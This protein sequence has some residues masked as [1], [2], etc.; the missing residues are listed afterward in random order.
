MRI[1]VPVWNGR[2]SPVF[3]VAERMLVVDTDGCAKTAQREESIPSDPFGKP[4]RLAGL[5]IEVLL[6]GA[7]SRPLAAML[8]SQGI[9]VVSFLA[10]SAEEVVDA[11]LE[12]RLSDSSYWMPGCCRR[13]AGRWCRGLG[14]R[15]G[16][17]GF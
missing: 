10:G 11:Y 7:V 15:P 4:Q 3:D 9:R 12:G 6:C 1:A 17:G 8:E 2:V 14:R 16:K 5:G 13:R